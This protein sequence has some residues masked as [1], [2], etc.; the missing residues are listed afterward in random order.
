MPAM[1]GGAQSRACEKMVGPM[2]YNVTMWRRHCV[3]QVRHEPR[4]H[5]TEKTEWGLHTHQRYTVINGV[6]RNRLV[7][8]IVLTQKYHHCRWLFEYSTEL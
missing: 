5:R 6:E 4:Q 2:P 3:C 1:G 7:Q 8:K